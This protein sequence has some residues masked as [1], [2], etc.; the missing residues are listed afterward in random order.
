MKRRTSLRIKWAATAA[1]FITLGAL[2]GNT[3]A[4]VSPVTLIDR[5][6]I[7]PNMLV[8]FDVSVS[9]IGAPGENDGDMN[10]VGVDC[11]DGDEACRLVGKP[12]RCFYSGGGAMGSGV[13]G[14]NTSCHNDAECRQ[15]YCKNDY[16]NDCDKDSD[17][18]T[19]NTCKGFCTNNNNTACTSNA[20][21]GTGTCR[22]V[23]S[24]SVKPKCTSDATCTLSV[25][26]NCTVFPDDVCI[27]TGT[28]AKSK[29][30]VLGQNRCR[31]SADCT[32]PGDTCG[33]ASSRMVVAK[34]VT[35]NIVSSFYNTANFGLMTFYQDNYY[36][37]YPITGTVTE[38][39]TARFYDKDELRAL[40]CWNK[41]TG[42]TPTC[43]INS[44][45]YD[46][47]LTGNSKYRVK[48]GGDTYT[49]TDNNWCGVWCSALTPPAMGYYQGSYYT[50]KHPTATL[51][52][53][54]CTSAANCTTRPGETCCTG[55][56]YNKCCRIEP[57]YKGKLLTVGT[58]KYIYWNPPVDHRNTANVYGDQSYPL[59]IMG[60]G[61]DAT[62]CT[63]CGGRGDSKVAPFMN[64]TNN[65]TAA[66]AMALA[67][68]AKMDKAGQGG[69][70]MGG[71]TPTGCALSY[72]TATTKTD[73]NN[74]LSYMQKVKSTDTMACRSN[75]VL[76]ITDGAPNR[77]Y[78]AAC[79]SAAC[80]AS[81][82]TAACTC[83]AVLAANELRSA[84]VKTY[85]VGFSKD[86]ASPY[87]RD[88][89]N[90]I[91]KAGGTGTA[92]FAVREDELKGAMI[93]AIYDAAKGQ[94]TTAPASSSAGVQGP[95]GIQFGTTLLD[96]RVEFPGWRG[97]LIAYET[98][99]A[100]HHGAGLG[101]VHG[102]L[103]SQPHPSGPGLLEE[104]QRLDD[105]PH[106]CPG[107]GRGRPEHGRDPEQ[108]HPQVAGAGHR[109]HRGR[110]GGQ[111]DAR[112]SEPEQPGRA[113]RP[114]QLEPHR[115]RR[116]RATAP[117]P[118]GISSTLTT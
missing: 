60:G 44:Q 75:Y 94:Y 12:G 19:G 23:C 22:G 89:L 47:R 50:Y 106:W 41:D 116:P 92:F 98:A 37:Y 107:E 38:T 118:A 93:A 28:P 21:C 100:S 114:D 109:R 52:N 73:Y 30:C 56:G 117:C 86:S 8:V 112:G 3:P 10:E 15:G 95:A 115:R 91:A 32:L 78:D 111:V 49:A 65:A 84:G 104:A 35:S 61:G 1:V 40:N 74:A 83:R 88:T 70:G 17:C 79:D 26:D 102:L 53:Q 59:D 42:P 77:A 20:I 76:L 66:R 24:N 43:T 18:G 55:G 67:I 81:P 46:L 14:D 101:R 34:R 51:V 9:M 113:G 71:Y 87:P 57:T 97:N 6:V 90:N 39:P 64:T 2:P 36:P 110:A 58:A 48:T 16:P 82:P 108:E 105:G 69:L 72:G 13:R 68:M 96:T 7:K 103:R 63:N 25:G 80:T 62:C 99:V 29:M 45:A 85:V 31:T 5:Q 4:N 54:A 11:D 27:L 33:N